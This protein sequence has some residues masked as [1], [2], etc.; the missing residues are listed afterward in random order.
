MKVET[1]PI[2]KQLEDLFYANLKRIKGQGNVILAYDGVINGK[3]ISKLEEEIEIK[4]EELNLKN[5]IRK[6]L[7]L[8]AIEILQNQFHHGA[9][10]DKDRQHNF[11][12]LFT[13]NE[14]I[15]INSANLILNSDQS[16]IKKQ[17]DFLNSIQDF[18]ALREIYIQKLEENKI[19]SKG[20]AGLGFIITRKIMCCP[21]SY[22]FTSINEQYAFMSIETGMSMT[23][24]KNKE[25][26]NLN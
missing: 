6:K 12:I 15:K 9:K 24:P 16:E 20:G 1:N 8:T 4:F 7:F 14:K 25:K 2:T 13:E 5:Q 10:D 21:I 17:I 23:D 26:I 19:S 11:F 22:E 18:N 3:T